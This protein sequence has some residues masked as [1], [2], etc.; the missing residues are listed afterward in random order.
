[1]KTAE[2]VSLAGAAEPMK[3]MHYGDQFAAT[4]AATYP[5]VSN[6]SR[7]NR[8]DGSIAR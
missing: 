8:I 2:A 3:A 5:T 1:M 4:A 6:T 7:R